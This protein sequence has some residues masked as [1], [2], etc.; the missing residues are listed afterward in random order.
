M[1]TG[2]TLGIEPYSTAGSRHA[3]GRD[4]PPP[5]R[6]M[7]IRLSSR[8]A[9]VVTHPRLEAPA[10]P[11]AAGVNGGQGCRS[12]HRNMAQAASTLGGA[13]ARVPVAAA[14]GSTRQAHGIRLTPVPAIRD[15]APAAHFRRRPRPEWRLPYQRLWRC[16]ALGKAVLAQPSEIR[17]SVEPN[18][19]CRDIARKYT[20][21]ALPGRIRAGYDLCVGLRAPVLS[22][23]HKPRPP[24]ARETVVQAG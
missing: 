9:A 4:P 6:S 20:V 14:A 24:P 19:A 16:P 18:V 7:T 3:A 5:A 22:R 21:A 11:P 1:H 17:A 2:C 23:G 10:G 12:S 13:A 15:P 8:P